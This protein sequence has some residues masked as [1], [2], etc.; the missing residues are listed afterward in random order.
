MLFL[1]VLVILICLYIIVREKGLTRYFLFTL[2]VGF[3]GS[4][5][6]FIVY[7]HHLQE[8]QLYLYLFWKTLTI[9]SLQ[10]ASLFANDIDITTSITLLNAGILLFVYS[11]LCFAISLVW[12]QRSNLLTY[13][14]LAISPVFQ[15]IIYWPWFFKRLFLFLFLGPYKDNF[16]FTDFYGWEE[17]IYHITSGL[18][19]A[20]LILAVALIFFYYFQTT[21]VR[22]FRAYALLILAGFTSFVLLFATLFWWAPKRLISVTTFTEPVHILP[23]SLSFEG[24]MLTLFPYFAAVSFV[25]L[26]YAV[27]R[28]NNAYLNFKSIGKSIAQSIDITGVGISFFTHMVKNYALATL[29]DAERLQGKL[30][31]GQ[32]GSKYLE[33]IIA[34]NSEMLQRLSDIKAKLTMDALQL[35]LTEIGK[36]LEE[37]LTKINL[38]GIELNYSLGKD[39]PSVMIDSTHIRETFINI[40]S[41]AISEMSEDPKRLS[42]EVF[43]EK[44]W[45]IVSI[46]DSGKGIAQ[47]DI[48]QIF[49]P[50]YTT[51]NNQDNWGLGLSYCYRVVTAHQGQILVV[52]E[53]GKGTTFKLMFPAAAGN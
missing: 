38:E 12:P 24:K 37:A 18:N 23:V 28:Y 44:W 50:F 45:V 4:I 49:V 48:S 27:F 36:P 34:N 20:Y 17:T 43:Q 32:D 35:S 11:C 6:G 1:S 10:L 30:A 16:D 33:R 21:R 26:L 13:L 8:R 40:L 9:E 29:V 46:T 19:H 51:K 47:E 41:N 14:L 15:F 53:V 52:S 2:I 39:I 42:V 25:L 3:L 22:Y 7:L 5:V 31:A